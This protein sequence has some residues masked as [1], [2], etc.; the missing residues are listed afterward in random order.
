MHP[1]DN[2]SSIWGRKQRTRSYSGVRGSQTKIDQH[3][4]NAFAVFFSVYMVFV[5]NHF[6]SNLVHCSLKFKKLLEETSRTTRKEL[7]NFG[8]IV[9]LKRYL[10]QCKAVPKQYEDDTALEFNS[11]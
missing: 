1:G 5:R 8:K 7:R 10:A 2:P 9:H 11:Y 6:I 3:A 4:N